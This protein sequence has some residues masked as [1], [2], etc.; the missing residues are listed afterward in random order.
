MGKIQLKSLIFKNFCSKEMKSELENDPEFDEALNDPVNLLARIQNLMERSPVADH[1]F[2][3][4]IRI[5]YDLLT[6]TQKKDQSLLDY[7]KNIKSRV[8]ALENAIGTE[9][10]EEFGKKT[11]MY[12]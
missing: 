11:E 4:L 7:K 9:W 3:S 8:E 2:L 5:M 12:Q 6:C 1:D 10:I